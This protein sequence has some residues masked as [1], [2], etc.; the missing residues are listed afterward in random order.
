MSGNR[1]T[2]S[3]RT[4]KEL[5]YRFPAEW[6]RHS[7][8]WL[9]WP[10]NKE[11]WPGRHG[12]IPDAFAVF[13]REL[14][15]NVPVCLNVSDPAMQEQAIAIL[16]SAGVKRSHIRFFLLPTNDAWM[17]DCGPAF[18]VRHGAENPLAVVDW[19]HNAWGGKYPPYADDDIIPTRIAEILALPLFLPGIIMEGGSIDV[20]GD[21][22]LLTSRSCLLH[23]NRNPHL[24]QSEIEGYLRNFYNVE[25][26]L[27]LEDGLEGDETDGHIDD[28]A[29]F[30]NPTTIAAALEED[31]SDRNHSILQ[32]NW[33]L[34]QGFTDRKGDPFRLVPLPMP[35][36]IYDEQG[37]RLPASYAN[38]LITNGA[39]LVPTFRQE[40]DEVA[41]QIL[42]K[43]FPDRKVVAVDCYDILLG[44]GTLHCLSQQQPAV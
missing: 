17:R 30:L 19:G 8:I 20:N 39:V 29:R 37:L 23:P 35:R 14:T 22:C 33:E 4:P 3:N 10:H 6:E 11:S 16:S 2:P 5:G 21:G 40:R 36:P 13:V 43:E 15:A 34:L 41:L 9:S 44:G 27:W 25:K 26:I 42:Q 12:L 1:P 18:V 31:K 28:T 32:R 38:F 24:N 7:A